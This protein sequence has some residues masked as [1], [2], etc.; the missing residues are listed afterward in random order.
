MNV[1]AKPARP[2]MHRRTRVT[3]A[4]VAVVLLLLAGAVYLRK[5]APPEA[6]RLLPESDGI[7]YI[8]VRPLRAATHFD[9][10][11][12]QHDPDYQ[13]FIDQTGIE[14][15]RDLDEAAFAL[16]RMPDPNG[17][18]GPVAFSE[19]FVG[20][21]DGRRLSK[22][23]A[24]V[25]TSAETY[26][27]HE[28]YNIPSE[29]RT[30][31]VALLG[32]DMVAV[33][34]TPSAEQIHSIL[35]R[36]R[37]AALPFTGSS[38]LASH[39]DD[40]PLLSL[41]WGVGQ[42]G[43]P[44]SDSGGTIQLMGLTLPLTFDATLIASLTWTGKT[45]LRVEEITPT[46]AAAK[47]SSD[48]IETLLSFARTAEDRANTG[49]TDTDMRALLDSAEVEHH[50]NRVVLTATIPAGLLRKLVNAPINVEQMSGNQTIGKK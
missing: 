18:N 40:V 29:K 13:H 9:E 24:A 17:P 36:Y 23:L 3:I 37:T 20:H 5:K 21:F 42:I 33:S 28:I 4:T 45:R 19:V 22:Y 2:R 26:A 30:V 25:A 35:D 34:N 15:E 38:L 31:R 1:R 50:K 12:V 27:G 39:Y 11:P 43:L 49:M 14:A 44:L 32:Y 10:H 46:E 8:N 7:V 41:A 6:A 48:S 16:H 47:T